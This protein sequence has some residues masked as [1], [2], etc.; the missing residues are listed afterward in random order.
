[1]SDGVW[2]YVWAHAY[3]GQRTSE[4]QHSPSSM[5]VP[6]TKLRSSGLVGSTFHTDPA[7][8]FYNAEKLRL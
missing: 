7:H 6:G 3:G 8:L 1:M 5:Q 4:S 2:M